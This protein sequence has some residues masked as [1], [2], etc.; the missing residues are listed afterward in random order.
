MRGDSGFPVRI[1]FAKRG[2]VRFISARDVARALERAFRIEQLPLAFTEGFSPRPKVSFGL[3]LSVGHE[4]DTEYLDVELTDPIDTDVLAE[5]L[6]PVLPE[7]MPAT[8]AVRLVERAPALQESIT[9][10]QYRVEVVDGLGRPISGA[11]LEAA[12][13]NAL[14]SDELLVTRTRKGKES[15]DDLRP[16]IRN[17][18]VAHVG[19]APVLELTLLTQ[20]RG[21]RT[22]EVLDALDSL[23]GVGLTEHRVLRTSQWIERGGAR[24]EPLEA[25]AFALVLEASAS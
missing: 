19:E 6:T 12:A 16:A 5:H 21:A 9:E 8:G 3:A 13:S 23:V 17:I 24:L 22:R 25:D 15:V 18:E 2:K 10:V 11:V 1:R 14:A 20:S 4:S 7:G